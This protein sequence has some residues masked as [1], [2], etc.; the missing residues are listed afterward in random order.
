MWDDVAAP[1][2]EVATPPRRTEGRKHKR[3]GGGARGR[4][5][6]SL[7]DDDED[8]G[9]GEGGG[10]DEAVAA[11]AAGPDDGLDWGDDD[12]RKPKRRRGR[13]TAGGTVHAIPLQLDIGTHIAAAE[14]SGENDAE[15][16]VRVPVPMAEIRSGFS[17]PTEC[18]CCNFGLGKQPDAE[19]NPLHAQVHAFMMANLYCMSIGALSREIVSFYEKKVRSFLR[20][21][22]V[23]M[24]EWTP[25]MVE[26]HLM[27]HVTDP[28]FSV[29]MQLHDVRAVC[30]KI[31]DAIHVRRAN[32]NVEVDQDQAKLMLLFGKRESELMRE[33]TRLQGTR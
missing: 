11:A 1:T 12:A 9:E 18:F 23:D 31:Q 25:S 32:G 17:G 22:D 6:S 8:E 20:D 27:A 10:G 24:P 29:E 28:A 15:E 3:A 33:R 5:K 7:Y 2:R 26:R 16:E 13:R 4:R 14:E 30:N 21:E 19:A